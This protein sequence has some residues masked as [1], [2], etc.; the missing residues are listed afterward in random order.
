M[1]SILDTLNIHKLKEKLTNQQI[2]EIMQSLS[3]EEMHRLTYHWPFWA[4]EKQMPPPGDW[5]GWMIICGRAWGKTRTGAEWVIQRARD[6]HGPIGLVGE[7]VADVR[8]TMVELGN[9]S[10]MKVCPPDFMPIYNSSLRR[11]TFP[12]G[13]V[14]TT[15]SGQDPEQLRGPEHATVWCD[16][17][18][19]FQYPQEVIDQMLFGLRG[20]KDPRYL[21]TTT[22]K[23]IPIIKNLYHDKSVHVTEGSTFENTT[24]PKVFLDQLKEKYEGT[25]L[26]EQEIHGKILWEADN[27]LWRQD[28]IDENRVKKAPE[29]VKHIISLDPS[30]GNPNINKKIDD[31]GI[32][33]AGVGEDTHGYVTGDYTLKGT[34]GAWASKV[35]ALMDTGEYHLVVAESNQG[36]EMIRETLIAKGVKDCFIKLVHASKGKLVRAEP[37]SLLAESGKIHNVG[38]YVKLE[39]ELVCYDGSGKSPNRLDAYV[40]AFT[41]LMTVKKR[42]MKVKTINR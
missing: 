20:G 19:K 38:N 31:C 30:S 40:H 27:A 11:L 10:I 36:G 29:L 14:A 18:A 16:E 1:S 6:G 35:A 24:N 13:V 5:V 4:R 42:I 2:S 8:D 3:P 9:S 32:I 22:P 7:T 33:T 26:G 37:I 23:P 34:P 17:P 39:E 41:E 21:L 15:F 25:R 12:N 28:E